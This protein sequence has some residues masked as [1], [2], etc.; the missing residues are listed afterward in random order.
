MNKIFKLL[1]ICIPLILLQSV[2]TKEM[3]KND[4]TRGFVEVSISIESDGLNEDEKREMKGELEQ[5][6]NQSLE[7]MEDVQP[8]DLK[9]K[10]KTE[11]SIAKVKIQYDSKDINEDHIEHFSTFHWSSSNSFNYKNRDELTLKTK[12]EIKNLFSNLK[13]SNQKFEIIEHEGINLEELN[14]F[15]NV[16]PVIKD[17]SID[18]DKAIWI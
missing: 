3:A 5:Y 13:S 8:A 14:K 4:Q 7:E 10:I 16:P 1:L 6:I 9:V 11:N 15:K 12:D 2:L 18:S 17:R